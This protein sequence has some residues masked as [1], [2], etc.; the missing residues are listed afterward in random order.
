MA[1]SHFINLILLTAAYKQNGRKKTKKYFDLCCSVKVNK[2]SYIIYHLGLWLS[3][4][5]GG[6][7]LTHVCMTVYFGLYTWGVYFIIP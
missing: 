1:L 2:M 7:H 3:L 5:I 4:L 6:P